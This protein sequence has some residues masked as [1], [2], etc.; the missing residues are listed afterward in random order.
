MD[1]TLHIIRR[2]VAELV[3]FE[4][5][6]AGRLERARQLSLGCP[7]AVVTIQHLQPMVQA[8]RD[9][10]VTYL[11][12]S[13][14]VEP[15]EEMAS[16]QPT[17]QEAVALSEV[18]RD[19]CLAF[20]HCALSYAMLFELALR[21]YEPRLRKIA[22]EHLKAH[23]DAALLT[24]R[25]LPNAVA[26]QLD[27]EGIHCACI[28]PMCSLGACGC[29]AY[30]TDTLTDAWRNAA[31][32]ESEPTGFV[33]RPPKPGSELA[34]AG[35]HGGELVLAIDDQRVRGFSEIQA[36]IRKHAL[37]DEVC[38]LI[39]RDSQSPRELNVRH[40]SDYPKS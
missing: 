16:P 35:V 19:L 3:A 22:P 39:Q 11:I 26:W 29:V 12:E 14:A 27:Q 20:H 18:L 5:A 28:C 38:L 7:D 21:L 24:A 13:C 40:V 17:M 37:G 4:T 9:Q 1:H 33:L 30:G 15:D 32:T 8:H 6:L 36:A 34:R 31:P 25:L 10:L 2:T 23:A